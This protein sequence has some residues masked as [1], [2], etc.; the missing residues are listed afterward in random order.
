MLHELFDSDT[1]HDAPGERAHLL[2]Q[3]QRLDPWE[4]RLLYP[5]LALEALRELAVI[6]RLM[7]FNQ[8]LDQK[9]PLDKFRVFLA[10]GRSRVLSRSFRRDRHKLQTS[11]Q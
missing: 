10:A 7:G 5:L 11:S 8:I 1:F 9:F 4:Q 2:L 6:S 3:I